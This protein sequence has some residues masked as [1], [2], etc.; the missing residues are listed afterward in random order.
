MIPYTLLTKGLIA[1]VLLC[2]PFGPAGI[3]TL[4]R[5]ISYGAVDGFFSAMG[6]VAAHIILGMLTI[7]SSASLSQFITNYDNP[8]RFLG[9][10]I[11]A[12]IGIKAILS[13]H[14]ELEPIISDSNKKF[15]NFTS[16]LFIV[17]ANPSTA[18]AVIAIFSGF[19]LINSVDGN[20]DAQI[21]L[22]GITL[23]GIFMWLGVNWAVHH[24]RGSI[25]RKVIRKFY[26]GSGIVIAICG[27]AFIISSL[28]RIL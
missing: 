11:I 14:I 24:Y 1:G 15:R 22:L 16:T 6:M 3:I 5:T 26:R 9:G 19:G 2:I 13:P 27:I 8:I 28:I 20:L 25:N 10:L 12:S 23:G 4:R 7:L 17:M 21:M 18:L